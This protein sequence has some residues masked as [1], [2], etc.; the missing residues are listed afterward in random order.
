MSDTVFNGRRHVARGSNY[1]S[2]LKKQL[3]VAHREYPKLNESLDA[4]GFRL[5]LVYEA[6]GRRRST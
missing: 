4:I 2:F 5:V 6:S 3:S 1:K